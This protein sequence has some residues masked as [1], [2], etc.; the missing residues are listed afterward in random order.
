MPTDLLGLDTLTAAVRDN[1]KYATLAPDFVR[2]VAAREA[3]KHPRLKDAVKATRNKLHQV[4]GAY[5]DR[6]PDYARWL[7]DLEAA[8]DLEARMAIC[9]RLMAAH[10]S[11]RERLPML[12]TFYADLFAAA[13]SEIGQINSVLDLACGLNP[14]AVPWM[15]L[16]PGAS[17]FAYDVY[18][19]MA[20]FFNRALP[21]LGI[22]HAE[23]RAVDVTQG[24]PDVSADLALI[25]KAIPCLQQ[26]DKSAGTR[27][28]EAVDGRARVS[29]ARAIVVTYPAF[30]LGGRNKGMREN[31]A[32]QFESL[33]AELRWENRPVRRLDFPT[34]LAFIVTTEP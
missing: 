19:D 4:A 22:S 34:E 23:S 18:D 6:P 25:I 33:L 26:L 27:V 1:P 17:Y 15:P 14:L 9:E 11:T 30:S 10:A 7:A 3:V 5:L 32:A 24:I 20:T 29:R 8:P 28:L 16:P 21:L 2:T 12:A 31:Y 13:Q